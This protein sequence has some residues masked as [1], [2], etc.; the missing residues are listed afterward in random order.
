MCWD[1]VL[2]E[3]KRKL[4]HVRDMPGLIVHHKQLAFHAVLMD[5]WYA[6]KD[7][8][9][10]IDALHKVYYFPLK[11]NR[12]VD[13]SGGRTPLSPGGFAGMKSNS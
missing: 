5:T 1:D 12:Q 6:I 7:L 13:D 2:S 9:L 10:F 8:M 3:G 4:D 11:D